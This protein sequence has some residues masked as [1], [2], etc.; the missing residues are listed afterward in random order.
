V[1]NTVWGELDYLV[2]DLPPGTGDIALTLCQQLHCTAAVI[3]TTPTRAS[4]EDVVKGIDMLDALRWE[5][6]AQR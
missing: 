6:E 4:V 1:R 5:A 3:V 2:M